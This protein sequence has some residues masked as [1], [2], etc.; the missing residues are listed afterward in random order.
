[1]VVSYAVLLYPGKAGFSVFY[2]CAVLCCVQI[3]EYSMTRWSYFCLHTTIPHYHHYVNLSESI[4]LLKCLLGLFC[5]ECV[6]KIKSIIFHAIHGAVRIQLTHFSYD[7]CENT[8]ILSYYHHQIGGMT[9]LPLFRVRSWN[10]STGC[11]SFYILMETLPALLTLCE[12]NHWP[13]LGS[14]NNEPLMHSDD[15]FLFLEWTGCWTNS[16]VTYD[17]RRYDAHVTSL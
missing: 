15:D 11:M 9:H 13:M 2:Y 14:H 16:R 5:L 17:L 12:R 1:M 3:I 7:D 8:C 4:E 10:N 6:S